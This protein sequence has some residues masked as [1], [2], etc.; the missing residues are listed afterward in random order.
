M[1]DAVYS[2][3]IVYSNAI[4]SKYYQTFIYKLFVFINPIMSNNR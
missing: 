3:Y 1:I 2:I 4:Y